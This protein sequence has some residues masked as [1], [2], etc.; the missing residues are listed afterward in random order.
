[1]CGALL[2]K[3]CPHCNAF[4][5]LEFRFCG[6]CG[7]SLVETIAPEAL[8]SPIQ[9]EAPGAASGQKPLR[10]LEGERRPATVL[11]ADVFDSTVI[12]EQI[13]SEAWVDLMNRLL[14]L[15]EREIQRF[16]GRVDQFRGDGLVAFFGSQDAHEDD[17]E[18]A[19]LAG[20]AIQQAVK[21]FALEW[22]T[23]RQMGLLVRVGVN[24]G[25]IIRTSVGDNRPQDTG[26]GEAITMAS[27][28]ET[29]AEPGTVLVSENTYRLIADA[30]E[31]Q[32]LGEI[33]VKGLSYPVMA[34][35]P[36]AYLSEEARARQPHEF[37]LQPSVILR[38]Q[39]TQALIQRVKDLL[40]GR[41]GIV[42]LTGEKG[43]G[44]TFLLK[45]VANHFAA[46]NPAPS[47]TNALQLDDPGGDRNASRPG[48]VWM[49]GYSRSFEQSVPYAIWIDLLHHWLGVR[50]GEAP[51][52]VSDRLR[53]MLGETLDW[54]YPYLA[55]LLGLPL[56]EEHSELLHNPERLKRQVFWTVRSWLEALSRQAPMV[57]SL[58]S[59]QWADATSLDLLKYCLPLCDEQPLLFILAFRQEPGLPAWALRQYIETEYFHR[60]ELIDLPPFDDAQS[61]RIIQ[62]MVGA[63]V[64]PASTLNLVT[65]KAE[66]NP[67]YI[68][69]IL[70]TLVE[71]G[72]LERDEAGN[73]RA[74][75]AATSL[76]LP[77]SLQSLLLARVS[78]L[79]DE[80]RYVMQWA[81]V[82]GVI[83]WRNVLLRVVER[84]E[85]L[86]GIINRLQR[87]QLIQE[88]SSSPDLGIEYTF[89]PSLLREVI[90]ESLLSG[91]RAQYHQR[92]ADALDECIQPTSP[93]R[94]ESLL[95]E[96]YRLAYN[97]QKEL[98][99][100][101]QAAEKSRQ[102]YANQEA[103]QHYTR[104]L[105]VLDELESEQSMDS[106]AE[107]FYFIQTQRFETLN[108]RRQVLYNMGS[109]DAGRADARALLALADGLADDPVWKV[110][111][112]LAQ[113]E[114]A[115]AD[116]RDE[117]VRG[118]QM[119]EE[120]L[121][122][123]EKANDRTREMTCLLAIFAKYHRLS[124]PYWLDRAQ[125]ALEIA[126]QLADCR[127][128]AYILL[129]ISKAFGPDSLS[130]SVRYLDM[131]FAAS[132]QLDDPSIQID[133]LES[134]AVALERQ[135]DYYRQYVE[136]EL[137]RLNLSRQI[138]ARLNEGHA[139]MKCGQILG[140]YLGHSEKGLE[141]LAQSVEIW[142][143][144]TSRL[145]PILRMTQIRARDGHIA[146]AQA[147]LEQAIPFGERVAAESGR[148]GLGLVSSIVYNA[149]G[150]E[151]HLRA[152]IVQADRVL[153]M[154]ANHLVSRQYSIAAY[155][156][157]A[158]ACR[159][160][161]LSLADPA[162][163]AYY[164]HQALA[165]SQ[166]AV[167][168]F[169]EFGFVQVVECTSEEILYRHSV[170]LESHQRLE[171]ADNFMRQAHHEMMRKYQLIPPESG[172][173][174]KYLD[175]PL[176]R[177]IQEALG[178]NITP[179]P[180]P[181]SVL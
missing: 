180:A 13:G 108:G 133:L 69:E 107:R 95:A 132:Q 2:A 171:E 160:L 102:V 12:L 30:F 23:E 78:R 150:D 86:R 170:I 56:E 21:V 51:S 53:M 104:A 130:E 96:H 122:L 88:R 73:W 154:V 141:L 33:A 134:V 32:A 80:E 92:V 87:L 118:A 82:V 112:L 18:R 178:Q 173:G 19:V 71:N 109:L 60:L 115:A 74:A 67:Y 26:M 175:M 40:D 123:A 5:P 177:R 72:V 39:E 125:R 105:D 25:E 38:P 62:E 75:R 113:P 179:E 8:A 46:L 135:G 97:L 157:R 43:M 41:G 64:L 63:Q 143:H 54:C 22:N 65:Q 84:P 7:I 50:P 4:N 169:H 85:A 76:E 83:F 48:L 151:Q 44:K 159:K 131:A 149:L 11:M 49:N 100:T 121:A 24:T 139:L 77:G 148:A 70:H 27:R 137:K 101:L 35:R 147:L 58:R 89:T 57:I 90:Y 153:E 117:L 145:F 17:P 152:A 61:R 42:I 144:I 45:R 111:A 166:A 158:E 99:Y 6:T 29:S 16:G 47:V 162:E 140:I 103:L 93:R 120:A 119:A 14:Q 66:G 167:N 91:Q 127:M 114:V 3:A 142:Q 176:H 94:Y 124:N 1:M 128:E 15:M 136:G 156:E 161:S 106:D 116:S 59:V 9:A 37:R 110:D 138:G 168:L 52:A 98:F 165:A 36:L 174:Q 28:M 55:L 181:V 31:W 129:E 79:S 20:L 34:Y 172:L 81:A 10:E 126:R 68:I 164:L 155:C 146:E 163:Q